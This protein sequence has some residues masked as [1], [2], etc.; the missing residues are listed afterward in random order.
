MTERPNLPGVGR[1]PRCR[2]CDSEFG[3][4][5]S[6]PVHGV[7]CKHGVPRHEGCERCTLTSENARLRTAL[8][9]V[10]SPS[11]AGTRDT[12]LN[13]LVNAQTVARQ[14]LE[15]SDTDDSGSVRG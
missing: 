3:A 14:A 2:G 13:Q 11:K 10:L 12:T 4:S 7:V 15:A 1:D 8:R 5:P 6:C 9:Y